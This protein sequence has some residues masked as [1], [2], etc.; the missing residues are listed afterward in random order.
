MANQDSGTGIDSIVGLDPG[1]TGVVGKEALDS[2]SD[3]LHGGYHL[4]GFAS[5]T[6]L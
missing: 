5:R 6:P 1:P 4:C 3:L 2:G